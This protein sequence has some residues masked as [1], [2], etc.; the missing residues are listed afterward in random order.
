MRIRVKRQMKRRMSI[1]LILCVLLTTFISGNIYAAEAKKGSWKHNSKGYWYEYTDGTYAKNQWLQVGGKWYHFDA[2]GYMQTGWL[3]DKNKWYYLAPNNGAM[4]TGWKKISGWWYF[5][6][7]DGKMCVGWKMIKAQWFYFDTKGHMRTGWTKIS[8]V[9]YYFDVEGV[10]V[11]GTIV[12]DGM[13]YSFD[14]YGWLGDSSRLKKAKVG[15]TIIFGHYEQDSYSWT[16]QEEIE[17]RVLD[18]KDG[19]LLVTSVY[20]LDSKPYN[21]EWEETNWEKCSLRKWLNNEFL[22]AAF[23]D[24]EKRMIPITT[25]ANEEYSTGTKEN[26]T[27]DKVF[28]LSVREAEKYFKNNSDSVQTS[29]DRSCK[30]TAYARTQGSNQGSYSIGRDDYCWW[31]LRT[32]CKYLYSTDALSVTVW[33]DI[34]TEGESVTNT[35]NTVRP[36]LWISP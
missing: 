4:Q 6:E 17:W 26:S 21:T 16:G 24:S 5:F 10:M 13:R 18:K 31:W 11:T 7:P 30:P 2:K 35:S 32:V 25:V 15:D 9:W 28:L 19:K 33:G 12:I 20:G 29:D 36:V 23:T 1:V 8:G 14:D 27:K 22:N 3:L 34:N